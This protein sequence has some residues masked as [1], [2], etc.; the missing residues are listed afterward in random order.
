MK[1]KE[2]AVY[3]SKIIADVAAK[4]DRAVSSYTSRFD[5]VKGARFRIPASKMKA[6]GRLLPVGLKKSIETAASNIRSFHR[7]E[8]SELRKSWRV[9]AKGAVLGMTYNP[10]RTAGIYVPGGRFPYPSTVLAAAIPARMA[11]VDRVVAV[12]PPANASPDVLYAAYVAGVDEMYAV[13]GPAGIAALAT[14]TRT[15][16]RADIIAGPGN[17]YVNE[18]K[19]QV[20]GLAGIDSLA[21]PSE[22]AII[23]DSSAPAAF[24]AQDVLAQLEHDPQAKAYLF[25]DSARLISE[26]RKAV[27]KKAALRLKAVKCGLSK[28]AALADAVAPEHLEIMA[29]GARSLAAKVRNAGAVFV[30]RYTPTAVGDYWAGPSHVLPTNGAARFSGGI[31]AATFLKKTSYVE[32]GAKALR[33]AARGILELAEAEGLAA[34][35]RSVEIRMNK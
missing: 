15:I 27:G 23:A 6:A 24:V 35:A 32:Y 21:G 3:I 4:G 34:H 25:S 33:K 16:P 9:S 8:L 14:G 26:V 1:Q 11:G 17:A 31:S 29:R 2:L 22:V 13:N 30:G 20:L 19:R 10:V 28:A 18:A 5:G 7:K 12:T